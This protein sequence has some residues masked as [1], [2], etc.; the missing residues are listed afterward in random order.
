[1]RLEG[2]MT[3][4]VFALPHCRRVLATPPLKFVFPTN[5]EFACI[6]DACALPAVLCLSGSCIA[7]VPEK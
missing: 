4:Q 3:I 7:E 1:M 6:D 2:G 5:E